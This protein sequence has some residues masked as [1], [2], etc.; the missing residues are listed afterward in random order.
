MKQNL[1]F[2]ILNIIDS[3]NNYAMD[4]IHE[5][6]A[7]PGT[8]YFALAQTNGKGQRNKNWHSQPGEN[9]LLSVVIQ[10]QQEFQRFPFLFNA[11]VALICR[12]FLAQITS[13]KVNIKW[14]NDLYIN[15]RKA[16]GILIENIFRG[17]NWNWS[18]IGIGINVNQTGFPDDLSN[19]ISIKQITGK[20]HLPEELARQLHQNIVDFFE[21]TSEIDAFE[22]MNAYNE[23]L[24]KAGKMVTLKKN[25]AVFET[26]IVKVDRD[27]YLI[28]ADSEE[29]KFSFGEVEWVVAP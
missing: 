5:G 18:V 20:K 17:K 23:C 8:A 16:G 14:P 29:R 19:P 12:Q 10:P 9:I 2:Q 15:D 3:S 1:V 11:A 28:T 26:K 4:V 27:G 7:K 6:L 21:N 25:E 22:I 24:Y 13:A